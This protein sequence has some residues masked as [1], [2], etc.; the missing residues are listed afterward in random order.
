MTTTAHCVTMLRT[1]IELPVTREE[2]IL[3]RK[4]APERTVL[5][6]AHMFKNAGTTLDWSLRRYFG[7]QFV[8]HR[9][10]EAMRDNRVYLATYLCDHP[11]IKALSSHWLPMP[12][13]LHTEF[14]SRT[15]L[16]LRDP[17]ERCRSV[18]NFERTQAGESIG[19]QKARDLTFPEYINWR[20]LPAT[21]PV[22]KN[23]HTRYCSG[24]YFGKDMKQLFAKAMTNLESLPLTGLV[25]RYAESMVLFEA[26]LSDIFPDID[27]SWK[28][29]NASQPIS[30]PTTER[31]N[32][33][34][35]EL[36]DS[37]QALVEANQYDIA[38][39]HYAEQRFNRELEKIPNLRERINSMQERN[40]KLL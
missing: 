10:D 39:F 9:D 13:L 23:F 31:V 34:E 11:P 38:L 5:L 1:E 2:T 24:N 4:N 28:M 37:F 40:E 22:I 33:I 36:G 29:Q 18:Y 26:G 17:L 35:Q 20:L 6:H 7:A 27:L 25:H 16:L 8:D 3:T 21:G 32:S 15:L 30:L 14:F 12:P 19:N